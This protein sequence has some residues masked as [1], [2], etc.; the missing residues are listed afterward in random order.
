MAYTT[1]IVCYEGACPYCSS[2][3]VTVYHGGM[4]PKIKS[5]TYHPNGTVI[6]AVFNE[7]QE[8]EKEG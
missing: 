7:T 5:I 8:R 2:E 1:P 3:A 6:K 4:C